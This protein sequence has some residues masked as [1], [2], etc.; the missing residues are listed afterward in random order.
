[1]DRIIF[2]LEATCWDKGTPGMTQEIIEIGALRLNELGQKVGSF[3]SMVRPMVHPVLSPYCR[4]LTHIDQED[5]AD[6]CSC[7]TNK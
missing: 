3:H 7:F 6:F 5:I 4:R 1:M 2:D